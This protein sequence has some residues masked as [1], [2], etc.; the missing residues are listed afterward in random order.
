MSVAEAEAAAQQ[1]AEKAKWHRQH[2]WAIG[3]LTRRGENTSHYTRKQIEKNK[4][5]L[6]NA[7]K[8]SRR[9]RRSLRNAKLKNYLQSND[10]TPLLIPNEPLRNAVEDKLLSRVKRTRTRT[11]PRRRS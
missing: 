1:A 10:P 5:N 3:L 7:N 9:A 6:M 11:R 8:A 2:L 4:Q